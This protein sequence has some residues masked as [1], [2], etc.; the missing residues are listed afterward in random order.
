MNVEQDIARLEQLIARLKSEAA[1]LRS[2]PKKARKN[3]LT[4]LQVSG[5]H[6]Q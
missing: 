1:Y 5:K 2:L 3:A 4:L 6:N